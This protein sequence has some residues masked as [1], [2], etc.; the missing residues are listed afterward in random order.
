M[1]AMERLKADGRVDA[2]ADCRAE[3]LDLVCSA[4]RDPSGGPAYA[5]QRLKSVR[6]VKLRAMQRRNLVN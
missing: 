4:L 2:E 1:L 5:T 3:Y 6:A